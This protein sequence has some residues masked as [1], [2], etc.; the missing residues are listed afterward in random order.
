MTKSIAILF[1]ENEL[2]NQVRRYC[3]GY[4][5]RIWREEGIEAIPV[6]GITEF[7]PA[8]LAILH[9]DLTMV[10]DS[11]I[12]F[13]QRYPVVLNGRI[14]DIR[15]SLFSRQRI[16]ESDNYEGKVIVKSE[17]NFAGG[18]ERKLMGTASSRLKSRITSH[19]PRLRP[20][21]QHDGPHFRSPRDYV[22]FD[23]SRSV[24]KSWFYRN[25]LIVEKFL[26][27][28][29]N[30]LYCV[31]CYSFLGDSGYCMM[32]M[33]TNPIVNTATVV[34]RCRIDPDP[35][36]VTL[37]RTLGMDYGK[38]DYV[39]HEGQLVLFDVN[40]TPGGRNSPTFLALCRELAKGIRFYL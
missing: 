30:G 16:L 31:R 25:D 2:K 38:L 10:P 35:E 27:E 3:I 23:N 26:P 40:K 5:S 1:H 8:D 33:S 28:L 39:M 4:M 34:S 12:E 21:I 36:I 11:Y 14:R 22:I 6:F 9:I 19:L 7:I 13:A 15:K 29:S 24:P 37:A 32:R 20:V 17:W 18:P